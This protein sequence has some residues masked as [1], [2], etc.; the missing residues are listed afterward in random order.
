MLFFSTRT[1]I[2]YVKIKSKQLVTVATGMKQVLNYHPTVSC[3]EINSFLHAG[4]LQKTEYVALLSDHI[5]MLTK[6]CF[7]IIENKYLN[8]F[9]KLYHYHHLS[10]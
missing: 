6:F 5:P 10:S 4:C 9:S 2:K 7:L 3:F 8:S 1:E